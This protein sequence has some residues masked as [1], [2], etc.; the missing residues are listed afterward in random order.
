MKTLELP[1]SCTNQIAL[2]S[3]LSGSPGKTSCRCALSIPFK[4]MTFNRS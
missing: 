1:G 3:A 2:N 4:Q